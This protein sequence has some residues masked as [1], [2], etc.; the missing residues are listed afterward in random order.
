[1][2]LI[3]LRGAK[4]LSLL[5]GRGSARVL[6]VAVPIVFFHFAVELLGEVA[7]PFGDCLLRLLETLLNVL[8][9]LG[10]VVCNLYR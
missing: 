1:M 2:H 6:G 9:D 5:W 3:R 4:V 8:A 7:D 10:E